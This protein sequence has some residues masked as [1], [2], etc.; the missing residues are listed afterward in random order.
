LHR[1]SPIIRAKSVLDV[2]NS[3]AAFR[4]PVESIGDELRFPTSLAQW[5]RR[6][7]VPGAP[8]Q[9]GI[10]RGPAHGS[11]ARAVA[12]NVAPEVLARPS[13]PLGGGVWR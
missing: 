5:S 4:P 8:K 12:V 9:H 2:N 7:A 13:S 3:G 10:P 1:R 6:G 11:L